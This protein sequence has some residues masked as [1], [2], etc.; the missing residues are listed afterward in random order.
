M[1]IASFL[2]LLLPLVFLQIFLYRLGSVRQSSD[3]YNLWQGDILIA[4]ALWGGLLVVINEGLSLFYAINRAWLAIAWS[5]VLIVVFMMNRR[6]GRIMVGWKRMKDGFRL[7]S[8]MEMG[9]LTAMGVIAGLLFLVAVVA[10]SNN[11]DAMQYHLPRVLHW[12]QNQSL[13]HYPITR[14]AQNIRPYWAEAAILQVRVLSGNDRLVNLVQW[15]SMIASIVGA[16]GIVALFGGDRRTR[17][18]CAAV[19]IIIPIGVLQSTTAQNDIV[20]AFWVICLAYFIVLSMKRRL[21]RVEF[22]CLALALGLGMLTKGTFFPY[23][24]P[25]LA[26]FLITRFI[27]VG[28]KSVVAERI[29]FALVSVLLNGAFWTR[30]VIS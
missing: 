12:A 5:I 18:L 22:V 11:V 7:K 3:G 1:I 4:A 30:N 20:S 21:M 23:A 6:T 16:T 13:R 15:F 17:W 19:V 10:P 27:K 9:L 14:I 25:L 26:W 28:F 8:K 2:I 24:A 29:A